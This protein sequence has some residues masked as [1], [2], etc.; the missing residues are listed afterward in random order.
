MKTLQILLYCA[1]VIFLISSCSTGK[2]YVKTISYYGVP[3]SNNTNYYK[4]NIESNS[5]LSKLNYESG[6]Y[7]E[8]A[9][10]RLFGNTSS[11]ATIKVLETQNVLTDQYNET[12]VALNRKWLDAAADIEVPDSE[13]QTYLN[14]RRRLLAYP[15]LGFMPLKNAFELEY[16]PERS[17]A[18]AHANEKFAIVVSANPNEVVGKIS[19][20]AESDKTTMEIN[21]IGNLLKT[22]FANSIIKMKAKYEVDNEFDN[23]ILVS[24]LQTLNSLA[25]RGAG[26]VTQDEAIR[27]VLTLKTLIESL[28]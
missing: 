1:L 11:D 9:L 15:N 27:E 26:A 4:V 16:N 28:K 2:T 22:D 5:K 19:S 7:P 3:S 8:S 10:D 24:Q 17:I 25:K 18:I 14:A 20:F 21:R 12:I 6:W 23:K 13:L